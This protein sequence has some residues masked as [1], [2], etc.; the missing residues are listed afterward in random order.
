MRQ[1][2]HYIVAFRLQAQ[3]MTISAMTVYFKYCNDFK[4]KYI[5]FVLSAI[6]FHLS[7]N[8]ISEYRDFISGVDNWKRDLPLRHIKNPKNIYYLGVICFVLG[9]IFGVISC[10]F[11]D[12]RL[13]FLGIIAAFLIYCY[14]EK[15]VAYKYRCLSEVGVF[16][17]FG[18]ILESAILIISGR[19]IFFSELLISVPI[20]L[21]VAAVM[22]ANNIRDCDIDKKVKTIAT[23]FNY[24]ITNIIFFTIVTLAYIIVMCFMQLKMFFILLLFFPYSKSFNHTLICTVIMCILLIVNFIR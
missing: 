1:F 20:G 22:L 15:P 21:M 6:F 3:L 4:K 12:I 13:L 23:V 2:L 9:I 24:K 19:S 7:A 11:S 14:S 10:Y 18:P 16:I 8:S 17:I 5:V